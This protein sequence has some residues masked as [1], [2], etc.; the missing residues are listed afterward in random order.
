MSQ[1]AR[2]AAALGDVPQ[3]P[4]GLT[5]VVADVPA[6]RDDP[7]Q[8]DD[9]AFRLEGDYWS[10]VFEGRAASVRD[11]RGLRYL[12]RLLAEPGREFHVL[13]LVALE[14]A[15][16]AGS[17]ASPPGGD[18]GELLDARA[19]AAYRRRLAEIDED[20]EDAQARAD[21]ARA[22]QAEVER[23]LLLRE[24]S[25]AVGIG[26][27]H[28]RAGSAPERA[29]SAVTRAVRHAVARIR[30]HHAPLSEHLDR[31]IRTGTYCVYLPDPR[32]PIVWRV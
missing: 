25:R 20:L 1:A 8:L 18:A 22:A 4:V 23:E 30:K 31:T 21:T 13:D 11:S 9:H 3:R 16:D 26:G 6:H 15:P 2:A 24:L 7:R 27:R 14:S 17:P 32:F 19:K 10:L 28:R 12:S 5:P 29:R